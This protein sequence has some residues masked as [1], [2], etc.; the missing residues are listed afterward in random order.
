MLA[1]EHRLR[2]NRLQHVERCGGALL[3]HHLGLTPFGNAIEEY[4][5][6]LHDDERRADDDQNRAGNRQAFED[7]GHRAFRAF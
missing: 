2:M 1:I 4:G 3:R 6:C 5:R 7:W